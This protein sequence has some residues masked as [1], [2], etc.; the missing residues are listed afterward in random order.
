[1]ANSM[2]PCKMLWGRPWARRRDLVAYRLVYVKL[3]SP[4]RIAVRR[5]R[6]SWCTCSSVS[7]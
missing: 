1:M 7:C 4:G 3:P 6:V 2:E 5:R